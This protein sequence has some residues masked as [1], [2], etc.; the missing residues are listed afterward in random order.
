[1]ETS[2]YQITDDAQPSFFGSLNLFLLCTLF[3]FSFLQFTL[4]SSS[5]GLFYQLIKI[6]PSS[7]YRKKDVGG[8]YAFPL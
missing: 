7:F 1:M 8:V 2:L 6:S 4:L 5:L 3:G